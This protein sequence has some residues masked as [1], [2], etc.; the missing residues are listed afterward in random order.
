MQ[1]RGPSNIYLGIFVCRFTLSEEL[2]YVLAKSAFHL[3]TALKKLYLMCWNGSINFKYIN[4]L[5]RILEKYYAGELVTTN[6]PIFP[7]P[8]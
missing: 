2:S 5:N 6:V 7:E 4:S 8:G 1:G 3:L